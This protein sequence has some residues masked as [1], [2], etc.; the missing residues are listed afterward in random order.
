MFHVFS[1]SIRLRFMLFVSF[2]IVLTKESETNVIMMTKKR[3][4]INYN[5]DG[6]QAV[7]Y[8]ARILLELS[9][10]KN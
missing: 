7:G 3:N 5:V 2:Y 1:V 9:L 4:L 6:M 10:Y 8:D